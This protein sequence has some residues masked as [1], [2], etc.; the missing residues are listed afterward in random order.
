MRSTRT[1]LL[2]TD[3]LNHD[4]R[5]PASAAHQ[6]GCLTGEFRLTGVAG[7]KLKALLDPLAHTP[8][9][10]TRRQ[11]E[12]VADGSAF[13][14]PGP[15]HDLDTRHH[16]QRLHDA[17]EELCDRLLACRRHRPGRWVPATVIVTI[18]L[19]DLLNRCGYGRSSDGTLIPTATVLQ[20]A[21]QA[22]I[23][24]AVLNACRCRA[25]PGPQPADRVA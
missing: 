3:E 1:A 4:R 15:L 5:Y 12:P 8:G 6:D 14:T 9:L 16:G 25:G 17:L 24:P 11:P 22:D 18:D 21:N 10:H 20:M 2:P 13:I 23:I 19:D 7:A